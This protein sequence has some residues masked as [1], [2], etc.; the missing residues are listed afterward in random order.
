MPEDHQ[1]IAHVD[2][3]TVDGH[4][5]V[6]CSFDLFFCCIAAQAFDAFRPEDRGTGASIVHS[7]T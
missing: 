1:A 4:C 5:A 6:V 2:N 3:I 7:V